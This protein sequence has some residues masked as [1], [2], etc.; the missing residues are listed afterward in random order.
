MLDDI[1]DQDSIPSQEAPK[2]NK[3]EVKAKNKRKKRKKSRSMYSGSES[4][5]SANDSGKD[6]GKP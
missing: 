4:D 5:W 1:S 3:G 6:Y 2:V